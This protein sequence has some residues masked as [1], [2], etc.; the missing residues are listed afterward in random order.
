MDTLIVK[1][2]DGVGN[3]LQTV[4]DDLAKLWHADTP[5]ILVHGGSTHSNEIATKLGFPPQ[6]VTSPNG[7]VSRRTDSETLKIFTMDS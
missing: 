7:F 2:G 3:Q 4:I 5:W 6:F 1:I